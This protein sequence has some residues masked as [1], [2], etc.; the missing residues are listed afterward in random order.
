MSTLMLIEW[1][2]NELRYNN[3][4]GRKNNNSFL[5]KK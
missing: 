1:L 2:I 4:F 3:N 5:S